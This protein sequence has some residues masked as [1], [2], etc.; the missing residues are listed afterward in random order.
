MWLCFIFLF[1]K[2]CVR[3]CVIAIQVCV[4]TQYMLHCLANVVIEMIN[5]IIEKK[6]LQQALVLLIQCDNGALGKNIF[7]RALASRNGFRIFVYIWSWPFF[8]NYRRCRIEDYIKP[9]HWISLEALFWSHPCFILICPKEVMLWLP[10]WMK[11]Y[12]HPKKDLN[13]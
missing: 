13:F 6:I 9:S 7:L 11:P 3:T 5:I 1:T 10:T 8:S 2:C 12:W 4:Y